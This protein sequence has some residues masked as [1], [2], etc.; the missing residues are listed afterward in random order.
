MVI[1]S[2][3]MPRANYGERATVTV[4][5]D[6]EQHVTFNLSSKVIDF[7]VTEDL[8]T[9]KRDIYSFIFRNY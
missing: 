9:R 5:Q 2:G 1:F 3:G 4:M 8:E 7:I 6:E